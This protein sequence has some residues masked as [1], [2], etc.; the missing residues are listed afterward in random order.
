MPCQVAAPPAGSVETTMPD[1]NAPAT[2][3]LAVGHASESSRYP[4]GVLVHAVASLLVKT[5]PV[6]SSI[7]MQ[8]DV[9]GHST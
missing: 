8:K 5:L 9:V 3:R 6:W 1:A 2:H 7:A 4:V